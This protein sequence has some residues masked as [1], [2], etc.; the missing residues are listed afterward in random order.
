M[1]HRLFLDSIFSNARVWAFLKQVDEAEAALWRSAGC[2]HCGAA[3]HSA[4]YPR[5]PHGL[6]PELRGDAR[7]CSLCCCRCRRRVTPPSA[8]FFGRR[9]RVAPLLVMVSALVAGDGARVEAVSRKWGIPV[10]TLRRHCG[11]CCAASEAAA[12]A[13][14]CGSLMWLLPWTGC[15]ALPGP[16]CP[17]R[18]FL[19]G[20]DAQRILHDQA[21]TGLPALWLSHTETPNPGTEAPLR[22]LLRRIR[23]RGLRSRLLAQPDVASAVDGLWQRCALGAG[24]T[25][26]AE[27]VSDRLGYPSLVVQS[28]TARSGELAVDTDEALRLW[29][30]MAA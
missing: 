10:L 29:L 24:P 1:S 21:A 4:T 18:V 15:C 3:L 28:L 27:S 30:L 25:L 23:G 9:F 20:S 16:T 12:C 7:R 14:G 6:A 8:R 19:T 17:Q 13:R 5:K 26:P 22:S 2:P 11:L